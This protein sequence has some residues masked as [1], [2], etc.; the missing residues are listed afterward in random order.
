MQYFKFRGIHDRA[1]FIKQIS[2]LDL[3]TIFIFDHKLVTI[4][5]NQMMA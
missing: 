2:Y 4:L 1:K 3:E 5:N